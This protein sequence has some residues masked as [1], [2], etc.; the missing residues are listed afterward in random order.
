MKITLFIWVIFCYVLTSSNPMLYYVYMKSKILLLV[1]ALYV[2]LAYYSYMQ[3]NDMILATS[4]VVGVFICLLSSKSIDGI[5]AKDTS[6]LRK[7]IMSYLINTG[8]I[9]SIILTSYYFFIGIDVNLN[10]S[11]FNV[12]VVIPLFVWLIGLIAHGELDP[13]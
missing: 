2:F 4:S 5:E 8:I 11:V 7:K 3:L 10:S 9:L 6:K 12:L 13:F 1:S